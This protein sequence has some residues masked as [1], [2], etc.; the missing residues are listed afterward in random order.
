MSRIV[1]LGAL[2]TA[3][4]MSGARR[5]GAGGVVGIADVDDAGVR[6]G[7]QHGLDV[8]RGRTFGIGQRHLENR[9]AGNLR[10]PHGR[11]IAGVGDHERLVLAGE[12]EHRVMKRLAGAGEGNHGIGIRP[13]SLAKISARSS[14][15]CASG[16]D[17][18]GERYRS[19]PGARP[20]RG[21]WD[22]RWRR[23]EC[24]RWD[25]RNGGARP[26]RGEL[27]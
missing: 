26:A 20:R 11:F 25:R 1:S 12:G 14:S 18:R 15:P 4:S 23:Y 13:S 22:S 9:R 3:Y 10:G 6:R 16:S 19:W 5:A 2:A 7:G 27:Q 21:P 17:R 8:V 24:P